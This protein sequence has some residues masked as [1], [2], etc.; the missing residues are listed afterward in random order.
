[1]L[2]VDFETGLRAL[3]SAIILQAIADASQTSQP[4][5]RQDALDWLHS[6]ECDDYLDW[7]GLLGLDIDT[8][9]TQPDLR[10][11]LRHKEHPYFSSRQPGG[12]PVRRT[13]NPACPGCHWRPGR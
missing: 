12:R 13:G 10:Q 4:L 7:L 5:V 1:M 6:P 9:L 11:R 8:L 3:L 2:E